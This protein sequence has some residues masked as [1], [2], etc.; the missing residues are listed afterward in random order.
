MNRPAAGTVTAFVIGMML[1]YNPQKPV[2]AGILLLFAVYLW[3][4][5]GDRR[6]A[7]LIAAASAGMLLFGAVYAYVNDTLNRTQLSLIV[8]EPFG[9]V[10]ANCTGTVDTPVE[11][12][13]DRAF[14]VFRGTCAIEEA[15]GGNQQKQQNPQ[16][17]RKQSAI[18]EKIRI[19]VRLISMEEQTEVRQWERG[20]N[21]RFRGAL[22]RPEPAGNFGGFDYRRYLYLQHIHWQASVKGLEG[23]ALQKPDSW[24][25]YSLQRM[26]DRWR[27]SL[28]GRLIG[29]YPESSAGLM[30]S[31]LIGY[32]EDLDPEQFRS[33]SNLGLTH[34][35]AISGLHVGVVLGAILGLL[36]WMRITKETRLLIGILIIPVFIVLTGAS[37]SVTRAGIM[38]AIAL[39]AVRRNLLKDG[40]NVLSIAALLMLLWNPY[41][42]FDISF[43]LSFIVTVGLIV[44]MPKL[45]AVLPIPGRK[46]KGLLTVTL[47]A[48]VVSFPLTI[49]YFNQFSLLSLIANLLI[50]PLYSLVVLPLGY[51]SLL[52][53]GIHHGSAL[54][55]GRGTEMI[56]R[57]SFRVI[58]GLNGLRAFRMIWPSPS[59]E[60]VILYYAV[61]GWLLFRLAGKHSSSPTEEA[62]E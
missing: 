1:Y 59:F 14:F 13:G 4:G 62:A 17:H 27:V 2:I 22:S 36:K 35:L 42:L 24:N 30:E 29:L 34:L 6:R 52:A 7:G 46:L 53:D 50:V 60:W 58:D 9:E 31:L 23:V 51:V 11:V 33:F 48:Q 15:V 20:D 32:R 25:R 19:T 8:P 39:Y 21:I 47:V 49:Y 38:A 5:R 28:N 12:D 37:P 61:S 10:R 40:L 41:F 54:V 44:G 57:F 43:Q 3:R 18:S 56:I 45:F 16:N 26:V 55:L